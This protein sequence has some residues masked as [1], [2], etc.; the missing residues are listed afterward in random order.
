MNTSVALTRTGS[1]LEQVLS[2][3]RLAARWRHAGS[4]TN[5][6][7]AAVLSVA[8]GLFAA[9]LTL[10]SDL[11]WRNLQVPGA[12]RL[13]YV[14]GAGGNAIHVPSFWD[15][16]GN[17][18]S[19]V[20]SHTRQRLILAGP[21]GPVEAIGEVV[22]SN[23][24]T[25]LGVVPSVGRLFQP[26]DDASY[27]DPSIVISHDLWTKYFGGG[28]AV[29][30][31][32][33]K[34]DDR[35]FR[36]IGV[37]APHF[38]GLT[39]PWEP[40]VFW[41]TFQQFHGAAYEGSSSFL[42]GRLASG[43]SVTQAAVVLG[44]SAA[45]PVR[46]LPRYEVLPVSRVVTPFAPERGPQTVGLMSLA[47]VSLAGVFLAVA[48]ANSIGLIATVARQRRSEFATRSALGAGVSRLC[49]QLLAEAFIFASVSGI[50]GLWIAHLLL[51][52]YGTFSPAR[53]LISSSTNWRTV[54]VVALLVCCHTVTVAVVFAS[55]IMQLDRRTLVLRLHER[56]SQPGR[57]KL[58]YF[59]M[60][61]IVLATACLLLA[62]VYLRDFANVRNDSAG[63]SI[64]NAVALRLSYW[65]PG[66]HEASARASNSVLPAQD[67]SGLRSR[68]FFAGVRERAASFPEVIAAG[69]ASK[70]PLELDGPPRPVVS[71][72][73]FADPS[74]GTGRAM[75]TYV[76]D[77]YFGAM[78]IPVLQGRDFGPA[79]TS[80]APK[81]AI[82]SRAVARTVWPD[83]DPLGQDI[84][85]QVPDRSP[86]RLEWRRVVGV[87]G[88]VRPAI[89]TR[90]EYPMIYVPV[91]QMPFASSFPL[92]LVARTDRPMADFALKLRNSV[93]SSYAL[94]EVSGVET[95]GARVA[96]IL[97]PRTAVTGLLTVCATAALSLVFIGLYGSLA[98]T[99]SLRERELAIRSALGADR[100]ALLKTVV[101]APG[102]LL[103]LSVPLALG[104]GV[105]LLRNSNEFVGVAP[106]TPAWLLS[107]VTATVWVIGLGACLSPAWRLTRSI[108]RSPTN[109]LKA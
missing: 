48:L 93:I 43:T 37:A 107:A 109:V 14:Y 95:L 42:V 103:L 33:L 108:E 97:Y 91:S 52:A 36:V 73:A 12:D 20:T 49:R 59:L 78:E 90:A 50:A 77:G 61:Q 31:Q 23:Y 71:R 34:L 87:V 67:M 2:D 38:E 104:V 35:V 68:L 53:Y 15:R 63:F 24:F 81:I 101:H 62:A 19:S 9:M 21:A 1:W 100:S 99:I 105:W 10:V 89:A 39:A 102:L 27:Q 41:V 22:D 85:F 86:D 65:S 47:G 84:A 64:D 83:Q 66:R 44:G 92:L 56:A 6:F 55:E 8:T 76:S 5:L 54:T 46:D 32:P 16:W 75:H 17:L 4:G 28:P 106:D 98:H 3:I 88:D 45:Q 80:N 58:L 70:L 13:V 26:I 30:G 25:T 40:S 69:L 18:F 94:A 60:P 57:T 72:T 82:I 79:D 11:W 51:E 74:K 7:V 96:T 29:I